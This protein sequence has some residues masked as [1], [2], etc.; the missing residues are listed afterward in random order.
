MSMRIAIAGIRH[1]HIFFLA[2]HAAA[3][4]D[5][6]I[7]ACCEEDAAAR[8]AAPATLTVTHH[9]FETMLAEVSCDAIAIGDYYG[10][11]GQLAIRALECGKHVIADKP[12]C[13]RMDELD[14]IEA[15]AKEKGLSLGLMLDIRD[16]GILLAV[17]QAIHAGEIG[18][19][20]AVSFGGQHPL[21]YG[22]RPMWYFEPDK[23]GG[24]INDIAIHAFDAIPWMLESPIAQI[25]AARNWNAAVPQAPHFRDAAQMMFTLENSC[26]ILGDV[27]Y[28]APDSFEYAFPKYWEIVF[29][30]SKGVIELSIGQNAAF[31]SK[32]GETTRRPIEALP[33]MDGQYLQHFLDEIQGCADGSFTTM[34]VL[35]ASRWTLQAQ[36]M[37]DAE[38]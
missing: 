25:N 15:L 11:R 5:V 14:R 23:H 35:S 34:D 19:V 38:I 3:N 13:T 10:K 2:K 4:P 36:A 32:N 12:L 9:S 22:T 20:H 27:S 16:K 26:G 1:G 33:D 31:L 6:E 29:W 21:M 37:A 30:G 7:V 8:D 18:S 24:T 17:R 28:L